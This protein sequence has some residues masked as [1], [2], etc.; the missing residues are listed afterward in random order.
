MS[1]LR[2]H[3][4]L[5]VTSLNETK[6]VTALLHGKCRNLMIHARKV[7]IEYRLALRLEK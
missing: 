7:T 4:V 2:E 1:N 5:C 3:S 6:V